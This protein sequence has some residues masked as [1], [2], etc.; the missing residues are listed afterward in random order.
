MELPRFMPP[1]GVVVGEVQTKRI[2]LREALV[3]CGHDPELWITPPKKTK[4]KGRTRCK[5]CVHRTRRRCVKPEVKNAMEPGGI[6]WAACR[7]AHFQA[8]GKSNKK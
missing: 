1:D 6:A 4:N 7:G 2:S 5:G 3:L 8:R